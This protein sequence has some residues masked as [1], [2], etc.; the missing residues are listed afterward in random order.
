MVNSASEVGL[1]RECM[2]IHIMDINL[3]SK[4]SG[5]K[6]KKRTDRIGKAKSHFIKRWR[7]MLKVTE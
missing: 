7:L 6:S 2:M 5:N 4:I 3:P 1:K